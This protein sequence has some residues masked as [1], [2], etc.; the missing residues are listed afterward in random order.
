M[1]EQNWY[2]HEMLLEDFFISGGGVVAGKRG[3]GK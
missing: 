3:K 1:D 2:M